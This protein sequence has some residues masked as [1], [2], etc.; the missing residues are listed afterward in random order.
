MREFEKPMDDLNQ[1]MDV[2]NREMAV[3]SATMQAAVDQAKTE[4]QALIDKSIAS[5]A[6]T[7]VK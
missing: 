5:G 4:M 3:V 6:A 7:A 1:Q 2:L